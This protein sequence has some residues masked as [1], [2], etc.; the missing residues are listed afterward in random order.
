M[1]VHTLRLVAPFVALAAVGAIAAMIMWPARDTSTQ[2]QER[3]NSP[4]LTGSRD[5]LSV[6]ADDL[7]TA[8]GGI[9]TKSIADALARMEGEGRWSE[10]GLDGVRTQVVAGCGHEPFLLSEGIVYENGGFT[11]LGRFPAVPKPSEHRVMIFVLS[12]AEIDRMFGD[13]PVRSV[14]QETTCDVGL[15]STV[16]TGLYLK[17]DDLNDGA[18][19]EKRLAEAIGLAPP[20]TVDAKED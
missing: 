9:D 13:S 16:T 14:M 10:S 6:C 11:A 18:V 12:D 1:R 2:T 17:Q 5:K 8:E 20:D 15:C 4:L 3:I 19:L 7:R